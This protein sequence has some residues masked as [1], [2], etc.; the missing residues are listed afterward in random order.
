MTWFGILPNTIGCQLNLQGIDRKPQETNDSGRHAVV[1]SWTHSIWKRNLWKL[2]EHR[3]FWK[4]F[5][6]ITI[7]H[8]FDFE[9]ILHTA[10]DFVSHLRGTAWDTI[11]DGWGSMKTWWKTFTCVSNAVYM[12]VGKALMLD[13]FV[14]TP[15]E[16]LRK[17]NGKAMTCNEMQWKC[18]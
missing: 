7:G 1:H 5:L 12:A 9:G 8:Q 2:W 18:D 4:V 14:Q 17:S 11:G 15:Y 3:R 6:F 10:V 13:G 16:Q